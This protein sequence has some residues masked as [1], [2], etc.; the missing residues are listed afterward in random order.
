M[1]C[2]TTEKEMTE[3]QE[4]KEDMKFGYNMNNFFVVQDTIQRGKA[5]EKFFR[6][7]M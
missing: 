3:L 7:M 4:V 2:T 1:R 5:L 6:V